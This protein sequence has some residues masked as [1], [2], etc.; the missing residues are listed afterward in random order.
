MLENSQQSDTNDLTV[1]SLQVEEVTPEQDPELKR[2][3]E[4]LQTGFTVLQDFLGIGNADSAQREKLQFVW[5]HFAKGRDRSEALDAIRGIYDRLS[6]PEIGESYLH[7]LFAYTRLLD[8]ERSINR[9][10]QA[11]TK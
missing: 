9:E 5:S 3:D 11:Y 7:K 1:E 4:Q 2:N 8:E 10:K 6:P